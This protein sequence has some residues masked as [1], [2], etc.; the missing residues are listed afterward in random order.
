M[1]KYYGLYSSRKVNTKHKRNATYIMMFLCGFGDKYDATFFSSM[2]YQTS[3][4]DTMFQQ[5]T[6]SITEVVQTRI[7]F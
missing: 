5:S 7:L 6:V 2:I 1:I 3:Q 4:E